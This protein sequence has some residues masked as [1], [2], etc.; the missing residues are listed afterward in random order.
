METSA[1]ESSLA[2]GSGMQA[3]SSGLDHLGPARLGPRPKANSLPT[4]E[5]NA[6]PTMLDSYAGDEQDSLGLKG[7]NHDSQPSMFNGMSTT[8]PQNLAHHDLN[9]SHQPSARARQHRRR[10]ISVQ[11]REHFE[12]RC[13]RI[14]VL[15]VVMQLFLGIVITALGLYMETLTKSLKIRECPYWAGVPVSISRC[16]SAI[17]LI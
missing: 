12:M 8:V 3:T 2:S 17:F 11:S 13:C 15:L 14:N 9:N 10:T 7:G 5:S 1:A 6:T 16:L 4:L